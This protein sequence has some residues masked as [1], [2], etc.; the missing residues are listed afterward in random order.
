MQIFVGH[1]TQKRLQVKKNSSWWKPNNYGN[2]TKL[3][4]DFRIECTCIKHMYRYSTTTQVPVNS[5]G[6][7]YVPVAMDA[8]GISTVLECK[9][10][11]VNYFMS[12]LQ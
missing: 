2:S 9:K 5:L 10:I 12:S 4:G 3:R 6:G 8:M 7:F 11:V 1:F